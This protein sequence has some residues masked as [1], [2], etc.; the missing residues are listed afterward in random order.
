[1]ERLKE[2]RLTSES[3]KEDRVI[4]LKKSR[5]AAD[6]STADLFKLYR[7]AADR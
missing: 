2:D 7:L 3:V 5:L 1:M 4:R 6:R